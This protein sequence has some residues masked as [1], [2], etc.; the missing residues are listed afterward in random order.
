M[1]VKGATLVE[2]MVALQ[3]AQLHNLPPLALT[4]MPKAVDKYAAS[5]AITNKH[6]VKELQ[7]SI[8]ET[9]EMARTTKCSGCLLHCIVNMRGEAVRASVQAEMKEYRGLVGKTK[10]Q[11][12]LH[13]VLYKKAQDILKGQS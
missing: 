3:K 5:L 13:P 2:A 9:L 4:I 12:L 8:D 11:K 7:Q 6:I 1:D 10:E